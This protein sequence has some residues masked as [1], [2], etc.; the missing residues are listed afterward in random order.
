MLMLSS[1]KEQSFP[2][3]PF[4]SGFT[5]KNLYAFLTYHATCPAQIVLD[6]IIFMMFG[7]QNALQL[8]NTAD[9]HVMF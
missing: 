5:T 4:P 6:L 7:E 2:G 8:G 1:Y 3:G 9:H